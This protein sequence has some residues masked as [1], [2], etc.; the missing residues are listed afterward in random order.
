VGAPRHIL[1]EQ[2]EIVGT[3][4]IPAFKER[5]AAKTARAAR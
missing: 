3:Q 2:L 4:V 5:Q 1:L